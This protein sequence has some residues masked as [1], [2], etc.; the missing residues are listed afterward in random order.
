MVSLGIIG[1]GG[2]AKW[3]APAIRKIKGVK[4]AAC[5]DLSRERAEA[6]A[7]EWDIPHV[8]TDYRRMLDDGKV[9]AVINATPDAMHAEISLAAIGRGIHTLCEKPLASSLADAKRM[10]AAARKAGVIN[11]VNFSYRNS[12]GLQAAARA[13]AAGRIGQI[14]HV[15]SS[16]LQSWLVARSLGD[17]RTSPRLTWRLSTEHG[18]AGTLGDLGCHIYDMTTLLAG[19]IAEIYCRL[20]TFDKGV[21]GGRLGPYRLDANDSFVSSVVF[22]GGALGTVHSSRWAVG[23]KNSLRVRVFGNEGAIEVDL[24]RDYNSYRLCRGRENI[25]AATWEIVACKPTP[26]NFERFIRSIRSGRNDANDF[27][28]GVKIQAY[29]HYSMES[30]RLGKPVKVRL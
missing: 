30:D 8:Y 15:E 7:A 19:D 25:D 26:N 16:Y 23:Q 29:L 27:A 22:A 11:M 14:R 10:L 17:W 5:C 20:E 28:N 4:L 2:I 6:Y 3:H 12:C 1:T 9:S 24:D 18:S 13:I 21:P